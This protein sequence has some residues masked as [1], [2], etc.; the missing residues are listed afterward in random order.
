MHSFPLF[1]SPFI[2]LLSFAVF[3]S[4]QKIWDSEERVEI[5]VKKLSFTRKKKKN[6]ANNGE[7]EGHVS[8]RNTLYSTEERQ[9]HQ[10]SA[11]W[12]NSLPGFKDSFIEINQEALAERKS[13]C[14]V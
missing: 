11:S 8:T 6:P 14:W 1:S 2:F 5:Y 3:F 7:F 10:N 4:F 13:A 9:G 12:N